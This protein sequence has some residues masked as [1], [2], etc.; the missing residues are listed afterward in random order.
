MAALTFL[1]RRSIRPLETTVYPT[2]ITPTRVGQKRELVVNFSSSVLTDIQKCIQI[3]VLPDSNK[4]QSDYS[5][6]VIDDEMN[7]IDERNNMSVDECPNLPTRSCY[8][9]RS[10]TE[11]G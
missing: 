10:V 9:C 7:G 8:R 2:Q 3:D 4:S 1:Y 11:I 6:S 5:E